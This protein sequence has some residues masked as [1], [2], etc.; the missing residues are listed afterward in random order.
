MKRIEANGAHIPALGFGTFQ[1]KDDVCVELASKALNSGYAHIDTAAFY[2]NEEAVGAGVK[3]SGKAREDIFLT[4]KVWPTEVREGAMVRSV[5]A[6]LKRLDMDYVD[7]LLIHW[8]PQP[9]DISGW[10]VLLN[11]VADRGLARHIGVSNFNT[12]QLTRMVEASDRPI[13]VNQV[14]NHPLINQNKMREICAK[15]GVGL[16]AYSPLYRAGALF[17]DP[18]IKQA[19]A[20]HGREPAQVVLRWHLQHDGAGAIPRSSNVSRM[21][22]NADIYGFELDETDMASISALST[23]HSRLCDYEGLSPIWDAA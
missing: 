10:S 12:D 20:K 13:A 11:D 5:E 15:L 3:E 17:E 7:L 8:P 4:T 22:S 19:A 1:L 6:S 16:I 21:K 23:A 9:D 18:I 2:D 14:E